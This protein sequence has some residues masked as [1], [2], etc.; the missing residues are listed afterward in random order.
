MIGGVSSITKD[1][2]RG[3]VVERKTMSS[4]TATGWVRP[5]WE[6]GVMV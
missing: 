1:D 3:G 4:V 2:A 6:E 5:L